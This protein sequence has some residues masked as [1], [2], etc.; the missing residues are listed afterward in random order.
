ME[1]N[2]FDY[3]EKDKLEDIKK[4]LKTGEDKVI[5]ESENIK[6]TLKKRGRKVYTFIDEFS[7]N[8]INKVLQKVVNLA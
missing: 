6:I 4:N 5:F 8:D 2:I 1:V 7:K 3:I